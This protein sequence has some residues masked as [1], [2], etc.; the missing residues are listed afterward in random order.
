[1]SSLITDYDTIINEIPHSK[2]TRII[3]TLFAEDI[4]KKVGIFRLSDIIYKFDTNKRLVLITE[5]VWRS[6]CS[7]PLWIWYILKSL[8]YKVKEEE[9]S[10]KLSITPDYIDVTSYNRGWFECLRNTLKD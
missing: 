5:R 1:M 8:F 2:S 6:N 4:G 9:Y 7:M 3:T 10:K